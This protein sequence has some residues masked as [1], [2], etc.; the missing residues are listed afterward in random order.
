MRAAVQGGSRRAVDVG[1][2]ARFERVFV[3]LDRERR[4]RA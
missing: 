2:A 3:Q 4:D 1:V